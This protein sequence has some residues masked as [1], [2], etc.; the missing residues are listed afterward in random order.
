MDEEKIKIYWYY[1]NL[2][3]I[4]HRCHYYLHH[5]YH[6]H[7]IHIYGME[8]TNLHCVNTQTCRIHEIRNKGDMI[9]DLLV[10]LW[11]LICQEHTRYRVLCLTTILE[12]DASSVTFVLG[13]RISLAQLLSK[14]HVSKLHDCQTQFDCFYLKLISDESSLVQVTTSH[15]QGTNHYKCQYHTLSFYGVSR[16]QWFSYNGKL[17]LFAVT[18]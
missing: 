17:Y 2:L 14:F 7:I 9:Y 12:H 3:H 4:K 5:F 6:N 8:M 13:N 15:R 18:C 11:W 16:P 10:L 1:I